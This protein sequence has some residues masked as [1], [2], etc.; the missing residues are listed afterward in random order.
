MVDPFA[1]F[2]GGQGAAPV[3]TGRLDAVWT[4][5]ITYLICGKNDMSLCAI[6]D[7]YPRR[8]SGG[9]WPITCAARSFWMPWTW[10]SPNV[11]NDAW[12]AIMHSDKGTQYTAGIMKQAGKRYG[13]RR[14]MGA[15]GINRME[16]DRYQRSNDARVPE[17][18]DN[19]VHQLV[20]L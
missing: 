1:S 17:L 14:S 12:G 13:L 11:A 6:K 15:T 18:M 16:G 4:S 2:P 3:R 10:R 7:E 5:D 9:W 19:V 8:S 20:R